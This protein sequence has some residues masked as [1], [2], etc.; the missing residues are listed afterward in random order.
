[1]QCFEQKAPWSK[2]LKRLPFHW[3]TSIRKF[4]IVFRK[5]ICRS[6]MVWVLVGNLC[7]QNLKHQSCSTK[8]SVNKFLWVGTRQTVWEENRQKVCRFCIFH[9]SISN[10][11]PRRYKPYLEK[12]K[13]CPAT[14]H[15]HYSAFAELVM[16]NK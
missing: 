13:L 6:L 10:H 14:I 1:M 4:G 2:C 12:H 7:P 15:W 9:C 11:K 3:L 5:Q 8:V 16:D